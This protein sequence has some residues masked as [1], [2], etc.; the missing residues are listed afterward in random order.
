MKLIV[1]RATESDID[2]LLPL[3]QQLFSLEADFNFDPGRV[4]QALTAI[5]QQHECAT[6]LVAK[7]EYKVVGMCPAPLL[8]S[9]AEG[10]LSAWVEDV[11]V[12]EAFR[13]RGVGTQLLEHLTGW[14][15]EHGVKRMQL[16][17]DRDNRAA[18]DFYRDNGWLNTNLDVLQIR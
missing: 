6:L 9:T 1:E 7:S 3:L 4:K 14:C 15:R 13:C 5:L 16:V 11:V 8:V 2:Q 10:G 12:H 17:A 18:L